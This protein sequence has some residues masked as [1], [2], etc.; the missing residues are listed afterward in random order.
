MSD[1]KSSTYIPNAPAFYISLISEY[2]SSTYSPDPE[3]L[4]VL[5]EELPKQHYRGTCCVFAE[6]E[7]VS[8]YIK[9]ELF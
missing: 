8:W 6:Q 3:V 9:F 1:C 4:S 2:A 5:C 7:E